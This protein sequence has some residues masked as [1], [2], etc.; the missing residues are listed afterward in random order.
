[1]RLNNA[2]IVLALML[3]V[4]S[5]GAQEKVESEVDIHKNV[6]LIEM[7]VPQSIPEDLRNKYQAFLPLFV[8]ALKESTS[9]QA[10][11]NA[12]TIRI[13]PGVKEIGS[14]KTKRVFAKIT[15]YRRNS[16]S[17]YVGSL[18]LHSYATGGAVNKEEIGEFLAKQILSP[19]GVS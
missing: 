8:E 19:L 5:L 14:A 17:E 3:L 9:D 18:L 7:A 12:L 2:S 11:E 13:V 15:A 6:I 4:G 10:S 16:R 1:M